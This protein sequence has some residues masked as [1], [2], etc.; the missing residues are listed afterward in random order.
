MLIEFVGPWTKL[1]GK[2]HSDN[3][4]FFFFY[5]KSIQR[6]FFLQ[7]K[8]TSPTLPP[9]PSI[10]CQ[11]LPQL[12]RQ[13]K[14][15]ALRRVSAQADGNLSS[16]FLP[17]PL[18]CVTHMFW[19]AGSSPRDQRHRGEKERLR[20]APFLP[21]P[22]VYP[23]VPLPSLSLSHPPLN[24]SLGNKSRPGQ[25]KAPSAHECERH[26]RQSR[27]TSPQTPPQPPFK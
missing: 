14:P 15:L 12:T 1:S 10:F 5:K 7:K 4:F 27:N 13:W 16:H 23:S 6:T 24:L 3:S 21:P 26:D 19:S 20:A 8:K 17:A 11:A 18:P 2:S 9:H 22:P 25:E